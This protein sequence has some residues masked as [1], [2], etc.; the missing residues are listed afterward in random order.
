MLRHFVVCGNNLSYIILHLVSFLCTFPLVSLTWKFPTLIVDY[1]LTRN[2]F[3]SRIDVYNGVRSQVE[4]HKVIS[5]LVPELVNILVRSEFSHTCIIISFFTNF[6][7]HLTNLH[8]FASF[9]DVELALHNKLD[10]RKDVAIFILWWSNKWILGVNT[11]HFLSF[12]PVRLRKIFEM[13][14]FD[15]WIILIVGYYI[16]FIFRIG[17]FSLFLLLFHVF[18]SR[19]LF[20]HRSLCV[21]SVS[22]WHKCLLQKFIVG[23]MYTWIN[24]FGGFVDWN[25][26]R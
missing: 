17:F 23:K 15:R 20:F 26:D 9:K 4:A 18:L 10:L 3:R 11:R 24:I 2:I 13:E 21:C 14:N 16:S 8:L 12:S 22:N 6:N 25:I 1:V 5:D 7:L 19:F